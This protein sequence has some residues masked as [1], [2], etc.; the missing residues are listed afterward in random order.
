LHHGNFVVAYRY[1][2]GVA[3]AGDVHPCRKI[4]VAPARNWRT[5]SHILTAVA[6]NPSEAVRVRLAANR[7]APTTV[8]RKLAADPF[9]VVRNAV[10]GNSRLPIGNLRLVAADRNPHIQSRAVL[11]ARTG[12]AGP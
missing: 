2:R 11:Q 10:V 1:C 4:Y 6:D 3:A 12:R 9:F 7:R 8:L 5:P